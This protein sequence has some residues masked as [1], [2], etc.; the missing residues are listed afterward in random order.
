MD[1]F[2]PSSSAP[3]QE[4]FASA[5]A[6]STAKQPP[7]SSPATPQ[8]GNGIELTLRNL[9]LSVIPPPSILTRV[10]R[11]LRLAPNPE[12]SVPSN[13]QQ[14][15]V[16][17]NLTAFDDEEP[18]PIDGQSPIHTAINTPGS[19][20]LSDRDLRHVGINIFRDV[21][22][23]VKPGQVC[24]ILG[25]SGSGKTTLLNTIAGRMTGPEVTMS[26]DIRCNGLKAKK[27]W[28]DGSVGYLQQHDF[29]MP[30]LTV[31]E[32][33]TYAAHLRLPRSMSKQKKQ[34]LVELV[35][36]ELGLK[37]CADT[38]VG[39]PGGGESGS[40]GIRGISGG[41]RRRVS[42]GIQLL[43]NPKMLLC[44]EVTSG[45]SR[46]LVMKTLTK[47]AR[48]SQKTIIISIHQPRSEIFKLLAESDGQMVLLSRGDVVYSGPVRSV[49]PWVESTGVGACPSGVNPFDH[50]LDLSMVDFAS[51]AIEKATAVRRDLLVQAWVDRKRN[52][53]FATLTSWAENGGESS[54][55]H[56]NVSSSFVTLVVDIIPTGAGPS[57]LS[58]IRVLTSRGWLNQVRDSIVLW[59]CVAECIVI[60]LAIG[61]I[62][63][64]LDDSLESIRSRTSLVYTVGAAQA[65]LMLM[66]LVY[67]LSQEIV[68]YDR[69]RMDR[70]Y[71]PLP[72]LV[73]SVLFSI[74]PNIVYPVL[75]SSIVYYMT[76]LRTDS[77][78]HFG[79]WLLVNVG[80]QLVTFAFAVCCSSVVRGF[81]S[82][83]LFANAIFAFFG[84]STGF[85]IV[86]SSIPVWLRWIKYLAYPNLCYSILASNELTDNIFTC[87]YV[88]PNGA[89]DELLCA[90]YNGNNVLVNQLDLKTDYF[91]GP[92]VYLVYYFFGFLFL[93]WVALTV[94]VVNPTSMGSGPTLMDVFINQAAKMFSRKK[95]V[96]VRQTDS[97]ASSDTSVDL[98]KAKLEE[99][100]L[101]VFSK[102]LD[103]RDPVT[104]R[105]EALS[106][107]V[108]LSTS[109][110][111]F[112][113]FLRALKR[114]TREK[115]L[116]RE[117]D[118]VFP[119]GELT[120]I[121]GG[122]GAGKTSLLNALLHRTPANIKIQGAIYYNDTKNPSL[123]TTNAV[124]SY[125]RQDDNFLL[126][127]L[128]V[129]E[130]L[131]YAAEL[132]MESSIPRADKYAKVEDIIDLLG[133]REC[134]DV[135]I[136][137]PAV[138]G[139]SGGQ[140]RRVSI[141]IQLVT[142]PSCLFLDEP[143]SGLDALTAKA[144][145]LTLKQIA[146]SGRT[147]IC[148][149]H[150]PRADIWH[151]F[152]NVVLLVTGGHAAYSGRADRVVEYFEE[153]GHVAPAFTNVPDF[154][155]DTASVNLRS[156]QLEEDTRKI[157]NALV[158]RFNDNKKE[159]LA[160]QLPSHSLG[161]LPKINPQY[162]GFSKA[163][164]ILTRRSFV[165][166]FR[167]KGLYF[168]RVFQPIIVAIIMAIFFSPLGNGPSDVTSRLGLLQQT[169]PIVFSGMLNNVAMY[170][171]ERDIAYR[172]IS[173]GGYSATSFFF[174][175]L[176]NELP[177]EVFGSLGVTVFMLVL[178]KLKTT[179]LTFF[180]F[181]I[182]M[183]GF[184]NTGESVG[185]A[186]STFA[187]HAGFNITIMSAVIS[188]FSFMTGFMSLKLPQWLA[189]INHISLFKY[190]VVV[191][192]QNEFKGKDFD[193][194]P[195]QIAS[196]GCPYQ[197][198]EDVLS[199]FK[200]GD[201]DWNLYMG[202]F[203]TVVIVYRL[204][205]WLALVAKVKS[206]RW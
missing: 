164:P 146:A 153:A 112:R 182:V 24:I 100:R 3:K 160:L 85:F 59:G 68:V 4:A 174:S 47:L 130:T 185:L 196:G 10:A 138:K 101:D 42:A 9:S 172:E 104:I 102:G 156:A 31:R 16:G 92:I 89:R 148:T 28:N 177:L 77:L 181:W 162:A 22:L 6:S 116:L 60:G 131:Q 56:G 53:K 134:A 83:S 88:G 175:F 93:A 123:R 201:K 95:Q 149:I 191:M 159:M 155:L 145:V 57:L 200:F 21:D 124:T 17:S 121:L 129:R 183:F 167:Q 111:S 79:W 82:A 64:Q 143:T 139:C 178:T 71:G 189:Y 187:S 198:G 151:V 39:D 25:G 117:V 12:K 87:P 135:V 54:A 36:L 48:S 1:T 105:V 26:G 127:H 157:V 8:A 74:I 62:Y 80:M 29:L 154:I 179:V 66:I 23:T 114:E 2:P 35:L 128:T 176:V 30:F 38:R 37:E 33:L 18:I 169:T 84:L 113:G 75:F 194:S 141:G 43:T 91:P 203:V 61:S 206:N 50:L 192:A 108:S 96:V 158:G 184:I 173:D 140:R 81:S 199:V 115:Q 7:S 49:L 58:Q 142:E 19:A 69:E 109:D 41:E 52:P 11:K 170:P 103:R 186:F 65:Y 193:C 70:W 67:R 34:E 204:L 27:F 45:K 166:T 190:G 122:S 161:E 132:Q 126:S 86:T 205:A 107:S 197:T 110:W 5:S 137:S 51:E 152:D 76:A 63:Y 171:F 99:T 119:A 20:Q 188:V 46:I 136:G 44:D 13:K 150:Q 144:V 147:V 90:P 165:N 133:L 125:V 195:A 98:E 72:H 118:V 106:L 94:N 40:S 180:S 78:S 168:N 55:L 14:A 97:A 120:A 202:L 73:S 32:T 15:V 163:F